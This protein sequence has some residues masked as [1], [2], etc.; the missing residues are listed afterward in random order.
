MYIKGIY[1]DQNVISYW[2]MNSYLSKCSTAAMMV[3]IDLNM[4]PQQDDALE[5]EDQQEE[6]NSQEPVNN[7]AAGTTPIICKTFAFLFSFS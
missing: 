2:S 7:E 4:S 1:L 3:G 6:H 5:P